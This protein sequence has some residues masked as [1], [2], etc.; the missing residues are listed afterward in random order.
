VTAVLAGGCREPELTEPEDVIER[1]IERMHADYGDAGSF[2]VV[3]DSAL[4]HFERVTSAD[5][6]PAFSVSA[7]SNDDAR[8]PMPDPYHLPSPSALALLRTE[9]RLTGTDT[10]D[11]ETVYVVEAL[12]PRAFMMMNPAVRQDSGYSVRI[13]V[14]SE[15]FR[16]TG[17]RV[18]QPAPPGAPRPDA[19]PLV[20][21][22]RY[23]DY[24]ETDGVTLPFRTRL[25]LEGLLAVIPEEEKMVAGAGLA[26]RRA[27]ASQLPPALRER[28]L[29]E[30]DRE[31]RYYDEGILTGT[32]TVREVRVGAPSPLPDM[33]AAPGPPAPADTPPAQPAP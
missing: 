32:F 33:P 16:V 22:H 8:Q 24:R 13:Y 10:L 18:E 21:M 2:T 29:A 5:S 30:V 23:Q 11:G 1:M 6:L 20:Q 4:V 15:T 28:R 26:M 27:Q 17:L 25:R 3:S 9:G 31:V 7:A 14:D 12:N 19:G